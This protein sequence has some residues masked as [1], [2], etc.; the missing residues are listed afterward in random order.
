MNTTNHTV[1]ETILSQ[2]G[3]ARI[4]MMIGAKS[5]GLDG[6]KLKVRFAAKSINKSNHFEIELA[7]DDTYTVSFWKI[8]RGGLDCKKLSETAMVYANGLRQA[9]EQATGLYLSL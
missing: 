3:G 2:L 7:D 9:V 5:I 1:A 4:G 8:S 6:R